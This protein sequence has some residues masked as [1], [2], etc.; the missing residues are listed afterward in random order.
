M[1]NLFKRIARLFTIKSN[2]LLKQMEDSIEVL[3]Y[4][5]GKSAKSI[6]ELSDK[7]SKIRA[8]RQ[9]TL[10]NKEK[11]NT[12]LKQLQEVLDLAVAKDDEVLGNEAIELLEKNKEKVKIIE[13]NIQ[14]FDG[15]ISKLEEQYYNLKAKYDDKKSKLDSLKI[16]NEFAKTMENVNKELKVHYSNDEFDMSEIEKIETEIQEKI[17]Y[18]ANK[19]EKLSKQE[20]LGDKMAALTKTNRFQQYKESLKGVK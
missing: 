20:S 7:I 13:V 9:T 10:D 6:G 18:E 14:Y 2:K 19:N 5:L 4:E 11:T 1:K 15:V 8:Q 12:Y 3:E 17:Y 16:K